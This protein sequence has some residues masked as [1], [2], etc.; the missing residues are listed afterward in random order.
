[1]ELSKST[2]NWSK[3][4]LA[5]MEE[6]LKSANHGYWWRDT[7]KPEENPLKPT[8]AP[9]RKSRKLALHFEKIQSIS[10][11]TEMKFACYQRFLKG[12]WSYGYLH[13]ETAVAVNKYL[14]NFF[15]QHANLESLLEKSFS[16]WEILLRTFLVKNNLYRSRKRQYVFLKTGEIKESERDDRR[17]Y[18]LRRI[19]E[20]IESAYDNREEWEKDIWRFSNLGIIPCPTGAKKLNFTKIYQ[21]WLKKA[22][23]QFC[24]YN[25]VTKNL[26]P[27]SC[28]GVIT[29]IKFFSRYLAKYHP[30]ITESQLE[31]PLFES[32]LAYLFQEYPN[33][34]TRLR[35]IGTLNTFFTSNELHKWLDISQRLVFPSDM[36]KENR[37]PVESRVIPDVVM[38]QLLQHV[39]ELPDYQRRMFIIL[40]NTGMRIGELLELRFDCLKSNGSGGYLLT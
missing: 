23:K 24:Q 37:N 4:K 29:A 7:W 32:F 26:A 8:T 28:A 38:E 3:D 36:P 40:A 9:E 17:I 12:E 27:Q 33:D 18:T 30:S 15:D 22:V 2:V 14:S 35:T 25:L 19:Y 39:S 21:P 34:N 31:R 16:E 13:G 11:R 5:W 10:L 20:A 1:M 6:Q